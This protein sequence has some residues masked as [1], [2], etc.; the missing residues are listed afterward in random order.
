[1]QNY[2]DE[3]GC[4]VAKNSL[5]TCLI[6]S[7]F[8][9]KVNCEIGRLGVFSNI[10]SS[11]SE[12]LDDLRMRMDRSYKKQVVSVLRLGEMSKLREN[13]LDDAFR[14]IAVDWNYSAV[15]VT[16]WGIVFESCRHPPGR[17]SLTKDVIK[18]FCEKRR[19]Q[20]FCSLSR[21]RDRNSG[22]LALL[23]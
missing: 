14:D 7:D 22:P 8:C 5:A 11:L 13:N 1:M 17:A 15:Y 18:L 20:C 6:C 2:G 12:I 21:T 10:D 23:Q 4:K 19:I 16:N 9:E 3:R